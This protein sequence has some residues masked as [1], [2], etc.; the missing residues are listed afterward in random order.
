MPRNKL[1]QS[2][3][4]L[5]VKKYSRTSQQ[6][7][8][9]YQSLFLWVNFL[10]NLI[11]LGMISQRVEAQTLPATLDLASLM[12]NQ[13]M[14]IEGATAND[15]MGYSVS[16]AGDVNRDGIT[17]LLIGAPYASPLG[18]TNAGAA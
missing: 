15:Y 5:S 14:L 6:N 17:D 16:G 2:N 9:N 18:R 10:C 3:K 12:I 7:N 4:I 1:S 8:F 11:S 13:G